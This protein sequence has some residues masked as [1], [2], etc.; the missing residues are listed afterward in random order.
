[1]NKP[2]HYIEYVVRE[3]D[4]SGFTEGRILVT[5]CAENCKEYG[6]KHPKPKIC[7]TNCVELVTCKNCLH[8]INKRE[9]R[10]KS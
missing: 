3:H 5:A 1:M 9:R 8:V 7:V 10:D 4:G 2:I 6:F